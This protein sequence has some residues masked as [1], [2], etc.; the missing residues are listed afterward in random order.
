MLEKTESFSRS[1]IQLDLKQSDT[2]S[3][4]KLCSDLIS[5]VQ[6]MN[7]K[8]I[9][10]D[11]GMSP[12]Q[13]LQVTDRLVRN[14]IF[15]KASTYKRHKIIKSNELYVSPKEVAIGTR[16]ELK[17]QNKPKAKIPTLI[18]S[19][20][21]YV[22]IVD[23]LKSQFKCTEFRDLYFAHNNNLLTDHICEP[24]RYKFACCGHIF[25]NNELFSRYPQ[26]LQ[27][28]IASDDF[29]I[30]NP[31]GSKANRHKI[32]A[33]YFTIQNLPRQFLSKVKNIYLI[34]L[35]NSDDLKTKSTDFNNIWQ[36]VC[37]LRD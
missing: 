26:S 34:C 12:P 21:E 22:S 27:L 19:S 31:L 18:Q 37:S 6:D 16:F 11:N 25:K 36:S 4:F 35:C 29:E 7:L 20:F 3:I 10:D 17:K 32:C 30:C 15:Q 14:T 28:Q 23:T 9:E 33:V 2:S 5:C 1:I 13:A 24:G 8:L